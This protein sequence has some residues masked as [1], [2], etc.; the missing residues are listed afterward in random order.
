MSDK[1]R[2]TLSM[3][4]LKATFIYKFNQLFFGKATLTLYPLSS[5]GLCDAVTITPL[6]Q[7]YL[8]TAYGIYGVGLTSLKSLTW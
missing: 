8:L 3:Y 5:L 2:S 7:P 1:N 6:A 4:Y